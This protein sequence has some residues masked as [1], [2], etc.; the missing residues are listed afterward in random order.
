MDISTLKDY[1]YI[2]HYEY[3]DEDTRKNNMCI[4]CYDSKIPY[5]E[6]IDFLQTCIS[7]SNGAINNIC[8]ASAEF[9][10]DDKN[11]PTNKDFPVIPNDE[12]IF[13]VDLTL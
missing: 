8:R 12:L 13:M 1:G 9:Y 7:S 6:Y 11:K 4:V 3:I 10:N 2:A 5:D